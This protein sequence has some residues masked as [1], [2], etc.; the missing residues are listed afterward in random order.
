MPNADP[1]NVELLRTK[2]PQ[3]A[4]PARDPVRVGSVLWPRPQTLEEFWSSDAG[5]D[6]LDTWFS[7]PKICQYFH[8]RSPVTMADIDG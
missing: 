6:F 2:H 1:S 8:T 5:A 7:I 4:Q 3:P